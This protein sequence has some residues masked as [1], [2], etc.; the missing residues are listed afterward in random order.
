MNNG[1]RHRAAFSK[2]VHVCHHVVP[3]E[4]LFLRRFFEVHVVNVSL[5]FLD[6]SIVNVQTQFLKSDNDKRCQNCEKYFTQSNKMPF[7]NVRGVSKGVQDEEE[8]R[9]IKEEQKKKKRE[10]S[11]RWCAMT[12][13]SIVECVSAITKLEEVRS[14]LSSIADFMPNLHI[15]G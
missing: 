9:K 10:K 12:G 6:L 14:R 8:L 5:H 11:K 1:G 7:R 13:L 15:T 3:G 4:L 2:H